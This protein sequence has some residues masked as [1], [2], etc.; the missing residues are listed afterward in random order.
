MHDDG[1]GCRYID[2]GLN[3]GGTQQNIGALSDKLTH[4]RFKLSFM[5]L[6][7]SHADTRLRNQLL[8]SVFTIFN[9]FYFIV[10]EVDLTTALNLT[11][12]SFTNDA[13]SFTTNKG[14]NC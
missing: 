7:V 9:R 8:Q 14:L 6:P 11:Q 3:D 12:D 2:T 10:Q 4:D 13:I 5:H 1:V